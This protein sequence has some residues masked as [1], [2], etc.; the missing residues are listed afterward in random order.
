MSDQPPDNLAGDMAMSSI[1]HTLSTYV[2]A[3]KAEG[4]SSL[5]A[6]TL[7]CAYQN[8]LFTTA[9]AMPPIAPNG[10]TA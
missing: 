3:L 2:L 6:I 5:E 9:A 1:A 8:T 10:P 7:A 4:L